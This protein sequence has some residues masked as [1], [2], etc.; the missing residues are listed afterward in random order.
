VQLNANQI[1]S[2]NDIIDIQ[3]DGNKANDH[4]NNEIEV[5]SE[6]DINEDVRLF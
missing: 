5:L 1:P 2:K 6:D 3:D 4:D